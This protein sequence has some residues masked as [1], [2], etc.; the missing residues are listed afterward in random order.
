MKSSGD[1]SQDIPK[2]STA[3]KSGCLG[4]LLLFLFLVIMGCCCPF[5]GKETSLT[6]TGFKWERTIE[7]EEIKTIRDTAWEDNVPSDAKIISSKKEVH[8][9]DKVKIGTETKTRIVKEKVKTGTEKIKVGV[10]DLGNGYF[11]DIYE[12]RP[13]YEEVE[14]EETYEEPVYEDKPVY[15]KKITYTVD[16]WTVA[17]VVSKTGQDQ[18]PFWPDVKLKSKERK[19]KRTEKYQVLFTDP[20]GKALTY[21]AKNETEWFSFEQGKAYEATVTMGKIT[22]IKK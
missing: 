4:L 19:G 1:K 10:K 14:R 13:V 12:E 11:E 3:A 16:R 7:I 18:K 9:H 8:H 6:S 21:T 22:E 5:M 15:K 2:T 20:K 17:R